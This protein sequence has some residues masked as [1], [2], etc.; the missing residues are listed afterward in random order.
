MLGQL[1]IVTGWLK[2]WTWPRNVLF[3][4]VHLL[5]I[6]VVVIQAWLGLSCPLT[7]FE[8]TLRYATGEAGYQVSFI[9]H[10]LHRLFFF[11]APAWVFTL[12]YSL[13]GLLVLLSWWIY[14]PQRRT[15][16]PSAPIATN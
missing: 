13:F 1:L 5:A 14:P 2:H 15:N 16:L 6:G 8:N 12:A 4:S 7:I 10:W 11:R 9:S 3:R